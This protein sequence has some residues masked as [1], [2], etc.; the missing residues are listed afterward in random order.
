MP[1]FVFNINEKTIVKLSSDVFKRYEHNVDSGKLFLYNVITDKAWVG[2]NSSN[3]L[4]K[5]LDG[6]KSLNE[7]Y[8]EILPLFEGYEYD[9]LKNSFDSLIYNL[10]ED[11]FLKVVNE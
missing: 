8:S 7:I 6:K 3:I 2:N 10:I 9:D 4:L 5:N 1:P 11:N